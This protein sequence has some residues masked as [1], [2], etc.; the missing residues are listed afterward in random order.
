[1]RR[2]ASEM[3]TGRE[4]DEGTLEESGLE[5]EVEQ[6]QSWRGGHHPLES[7]RHGYP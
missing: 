3:G 4:I 6:V 7:R 1:M 5:K 2:M